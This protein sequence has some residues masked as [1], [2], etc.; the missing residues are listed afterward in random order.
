[1]QHRKGAMTTARKRLSPFGI[2]AREIRKNYNLLLLDM[3]KAAEVSPG[4]LSM[5]ETGA[6][7]V[8]DG[9]VAK[10]VNSLDLPARQARELETAAALSASEFR[11]RISEKPDPLERSLAWELEKQFA[12]M[13]P[14]K[15]QQILNILA[16]E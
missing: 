16:E 5:V 2:K 3:A 9:L 10:I 11:L 7:Q 8:P 13:T 12:K 1:M 14:I 15:R 4:F 6:K